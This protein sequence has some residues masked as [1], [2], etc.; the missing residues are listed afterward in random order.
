MINH[1]I[2]VGNMTRDAEAVACAATA[3]TRM[4]I[5]TN[6]VW[7]DAEG[8]RQEQAEFHTVVAFGKLA[9]I[10]ASYCVKGRRVYIDG[11][12]RTR[13]YDGS[14]GL[15]RHST[16]IVAETM[17]L[18]DRAP[19]GTDASDARTGTDDGA[20]GQALTIVGGAG[21]SDGSTKPEAD[22]RNGRRRPLV[23]AG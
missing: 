1:V 12:L 13:E 21:E 16:E 11:R 19:T 3:V 7:R 17:K 10:C 4:R 14:D 22:S 6:S 5:A 18:L 23:T 9:E 15:R 8:N 20:D 2:L